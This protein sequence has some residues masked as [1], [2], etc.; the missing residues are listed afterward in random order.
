MNG[1]YHIMQL[2]TAGALDLRAE[3]RQQCHKL[4]REVWPWA[5]SMAQKFEEPEMRAL[6]SV[7]QR[8]PWRDLVVIDVGAADVNSTI[9][10]VR[11]A[12]SQILASQLIYLD[13]FCS[14]P[15]FRL[16]EEQAQ[17]GMD[18][19]DALAAKTRVLPAEEAVAL[20]IVLECARAVPTSIMCYG[21]WWHP[22]MMLRLLESPELDWP[23]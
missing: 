23:R 4:L 12:F 11:G 10:D 1:N 8:L 15:D 5:V 9:D 3:Q 18:F 22:W 6:L 13:M 17:N 16:P 21:M 7:Y 19:A 2:C 20:H 14:D